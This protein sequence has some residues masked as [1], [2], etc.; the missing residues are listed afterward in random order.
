MKVA[1]LSALG[2]GRL[3]PPEDIPGTKFCHTLSRS[4]THKAARKITSMKNPNHPIGNQTRD[5]PVCN[6]VPQPT[7]LPPIFMNITEGSVQFMFECQLKFPRVMSTILWL[8]TG[9]IQVSSDIRTA[10]QTQ[11]H[12]FAICLR[13][14]LRSPANT[15]SLVDILQG[16]YFTSQLSF[17]TS[18]RLP[19]HISVAHS[20][21]RPYVL[22]NSVE[23]WQKMFAG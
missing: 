5:L 22:W 8:L 18:C 10:A 7:A 23:K 1:R 16:H 21:D 17:Y 6:Q 13:T 4:Q 19:Y 14:S 20:P 12:Y 2:T 9:L 3:Y 15:I 11:T